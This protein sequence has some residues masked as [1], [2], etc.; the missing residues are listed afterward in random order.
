[1]N[2]AK[3]RR[4]GTLE[5]PGGPGSKFDADHTDGRGPLRAPYGGGTNDAKPARNAARA[6]RI[7]DHDV[8]P[9]LRAVGTATVR[10]AIPP[11]QR[12]AVDLDR[13]AAAARHRHA[14]RMRPHAGAP[15]AVMSRHATAT[16]LASRLEDPDAAVAEIAAQLGDFADGGVLFFCSSSYDRQRRAL[17]LS[18]RFRPNRGMHWCS[19][20]RTHWPSTR[21]NRRTGIRS[22]HDQRR[23]RRSAGTRRRRAGFRLRVP[24]HRGARDRCVVARHARGGAPPRATP[25]AGGVAVGGHGAR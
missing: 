6:R 19:T 24:E 25:L 13:S 16:T 5:G 8:G 21:W 3:R 17:A 14:A 12:V 11:P 10:Q 2:A 18:R 22:R 20:D 7:R 23:E 9:V 4:G 1:M 15:Q